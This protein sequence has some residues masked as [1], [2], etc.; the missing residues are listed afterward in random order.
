MTDQDRQLWESFFRE[1]FQSGTE[2]LDEAKSSHPSHVILTAYVYDQLETE[3]QARVSA[4]IAECAT[5]HKEVAQRRAELEPVEAA[6]ESVETARWPATADLTRDK[7]SR[8][9]RSSLWETVRR[10]VVAWR[11]DLE[12]WLHGRR[13]WVGHAAAFATASVAALLINWAALQA[14]Q[15]AGPYTSAQGESGTWWAPWV[16]GVW[17]IVVVAHA[18]IVWRQRNRS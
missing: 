16:V 1:A 3:D 12:A 15:S 17:A 4:H 9:A 2:M 14:P 5:C 18:I 6:F 10:R 7:D 13:A 11:Q 8:P